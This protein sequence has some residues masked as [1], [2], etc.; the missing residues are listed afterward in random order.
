VARHRLAARRRRPEGAQDGASDRPPAGDR[1]QAI[2]REAR[3]KPTGP[4]Q[5]K[6][7]ERIA[8]AGYQ[9]AVRDM[10]NGD[11]ATC[12]AVYEWLLSRPEYAGQLPPSAVTFARYIT[13]A[14]LYYEGASKRQ[15]RRAGFTADGEADKP[16]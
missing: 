11:K 1:P 6:D 4:R 13:C 12:V 2:P 14:R 16:G 5:L 9:L 3:K 8:W 10:P 7:A 15:Q